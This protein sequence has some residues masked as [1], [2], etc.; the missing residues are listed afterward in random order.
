M[1]DSR[2]VTATGGDTLS[3]LGLLAKIK[4]KSRPKSNI[5]ILESLSLFFF[6]FLCCFRRGCFHFIPFFFSHVF[7][8]RSKQL[9]GREVLVVPEGFPLIQTNSLWGPRVPILA[10]ILGP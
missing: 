6:F 10:G 4:C 8:P 9:G 2:T 7:Y 3:L 1:H 5:Q